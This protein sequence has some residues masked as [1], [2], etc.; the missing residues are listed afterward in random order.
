MEELCWWPRSAWPGA[1]W[2]RWPS[3]MAVVESADKD[4]VVLV[5]VP[6][7]SGVSGLDPGGGRLMNIGWAELDDGACAMMK[8]DVGERK[9]GY[10]TI[11]VSCR[12]QAILRKLKKELCRRWWSSDVVSDCDAA[13]EG[14]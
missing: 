10:M 8:V 6:G 5:G 9:C 2:P 13:Q 3:F 1:K 4:V 14:E 12:H 11:R 7:I